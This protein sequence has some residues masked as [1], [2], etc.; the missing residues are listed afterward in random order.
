MTPIARITDELTA[1]IDADHRHFGEMPE[2]FT[3]AWRGYLA[4][5]L[6]WGVIDQPAY[7]ALTAKLPLLSADPAVDILRGRDD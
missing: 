1:R 3:I 2:R 4:G 5:L 7:D 6:E